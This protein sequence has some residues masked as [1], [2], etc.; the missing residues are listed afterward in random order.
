MAP[1]VILTPPSSLYPLS[2]LPSSS[3]TPPLGDWSPAVEVLG[4]GQEHHD[5][6]GVFLYKVSCGRRP[7]VVVMNGG[8]DAIHLVQWVW[9]THGRR[10]VAGATSSTRPTRG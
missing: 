9:D 2:L 5:S 1:H 4:G 10:A 8:E 7:A 3:S 6:F